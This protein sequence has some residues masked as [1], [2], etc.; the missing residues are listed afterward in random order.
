MRS[1]TNLYRNQYQKINQTKYCKLNQNGFT[2][3]ELMI[4]VAIVGILASIAAPAYTNYVKKGKAAEATSTLA[5]AR[6]RME[7]Y[8]QD[9]RTYVGG[10]CPAA[11]KSFTYACVLAAS[12]Y[13]ITA[14]GVAAQGMTGFSYGVNQ[15]NAKT[16]TYDGV[17]P[18]P[19]TCWVTSKGGSC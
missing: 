2:M 12:T 17:T 8:F 11:G 7:Q 1:L 4:V 14:T 15:N 9:N 6:V 19:N 5:D 10:P 3:I 18:S 13:T 16:S